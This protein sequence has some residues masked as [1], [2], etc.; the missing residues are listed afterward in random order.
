VE[1]GAL[2]TP[3][4]YLNRQ[5]AALATGVV[6]QVFFTVAS[7]GTLT[8]GKVKLVFPNADDGLWCRTNGTDLTVAQIQNPT[9]ATESASAST[10]GTLAGSCTKGTN[11]STYDTIVVTFD[12]TISNS[13]KYGLQIADGTTGK[14]GSGTEATNTVVTIQTTNS[15]DAVQD[16]ATLALYPVAN[17]RIVVSATVEPALSVSIPTTTAALGTLSISNVSYVGISSAVTTNAKSGYISVASYNNTLTSGSDTI[18]D[19]TGTPPDNMAAGA[20]SGAF[21]A[22]TSQNGN[23]IVQSNTQVTC[24]GTTRTQTQAASATALSATPKSFAASA[25]AVTNQSTTLCFL[26]AVD[27]SVVPGTY[28]STV[29]LVTTAKY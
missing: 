29:T 6:H 1:A 14:L 11:G 20:T 16:S 9:G 4:D 23:T 22:S 5:A 17:D 3:R 10:I 26:A 8:N 2:T 19:V 15:S 28:T 7:D 13:T 25:G 12:G 18:A 24:D 21:G 27:G